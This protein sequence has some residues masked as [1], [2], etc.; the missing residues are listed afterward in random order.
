MSYKPLPNLLTIKESKIQRLGLFASSKIEK[1]KM[2]G[3]THIQNEEFENKYIR[4]PLGGFI[5]HSDNPNCELK[6]SDKVYLMLYARNE[7]PK[8]EE[9][10]LKYKMYTDFL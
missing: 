7:I 8:D 4:T 5:N 2:I 10:T 6:E 9:I 1:G 3:I